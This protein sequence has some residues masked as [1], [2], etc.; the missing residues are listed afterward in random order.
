M[1]NKR[2]LEQQLLVGRL[3]CDIKISARELIKSRSF[4]LETLCQTVLRLKE[5]QRTEVEQEEV[6]RM[7]QTSGDI[8][9]LVAL[10]MQDTAY[11]LKMMFE[12]NVIPLALQIT[13]IAGKTSPIFAAGPSISF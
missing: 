12:L 7:F 11:I 3:A 13:N 4:D 6:P 5:G 8:L 2:Q 9:K 10:T 1:P